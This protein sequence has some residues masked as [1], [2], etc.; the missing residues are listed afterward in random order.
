MYSLETRQLDMHTPMQG[1][2]CFRFNFYYGDM[3]V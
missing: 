3:D 1:I 2:S